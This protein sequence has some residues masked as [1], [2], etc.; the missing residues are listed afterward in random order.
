LAVILFALALQAQ[1]AYH[2]PVIPG[3]NPDPSVIRVGKEYWATATATKWPPI[4][5]PFRSSDLA[6]WEGVSDVFAQQYV[7]TQRRLG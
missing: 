3:D 7:G 1:T 2:N 6:H 4:F 5:P